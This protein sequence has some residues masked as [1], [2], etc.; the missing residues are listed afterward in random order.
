MIGNLIPYQNSQLPSS[1]LTA[2]IQIQK[3]PIH[4]GVILCQFCYVKIFST[5]QHKNLLLLND[6]TSRVRSQ[7]ATVVRQIQRFDFGRNLVAIH[8]PSRYLKQTKSF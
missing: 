4:T 5:N 8:I 6:P 7:I 3:H 2:T 1:F